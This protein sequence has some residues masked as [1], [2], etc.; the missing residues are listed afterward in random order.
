MAP[1]CSSQYQFL[2]KAKPRALRARGVNLSSYIHNYRQPNVGSQGYLRS[3]PVQRLLFSSLPKTGMLWTRRDSNP[4]LKA[5]Q[6]NVLPLHHGPKCRLWLGATRYKV[7][8]HTTGLRRP[9]LELPE[10]TCSWPPLCLCVS[11]VKLFSALSAC[12]AAMPP[13]ANGAAKR[14]P[15]NDQRRTTNDRPC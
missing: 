9:I 1:A 5:G 4:H 8:C 7:T 6:A 2:L 14:R 12:S 3:L 15:A 10:P 13:K 11:V